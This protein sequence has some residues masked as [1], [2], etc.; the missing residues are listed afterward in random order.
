MTPREA[1]SL[2]LSFE[3]EGTSCSEQGLRASL[4]IIQLTRVRDLLVENEQILVCLVGM[5]HEVFIRVWGA[6]IA[7][8]MELDVMNQFLQGCTALIRQR[9]L[10]AA[11]PPPDQVG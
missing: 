7:L 10:E 3:R 5:V 11:P 8:Q 2:I 4:G 9:A 6:R 1:L